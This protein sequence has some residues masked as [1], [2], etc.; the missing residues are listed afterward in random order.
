MP[1]YM[2]QFAYTPEAWANLTRN[3]QDRTEALRELAQKLGGKLVSLYYSFG[4]HDGIVLSDVPDD[5]SAAALAM[6]AVAAGHVRSI[7]TTRLLTA[8]EAMA[9]MK[10]AGAAAYKPPRA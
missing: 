4:E 2:S 1:L 5:T 10:K 7:K 9:A 6:A 3:P 8:A